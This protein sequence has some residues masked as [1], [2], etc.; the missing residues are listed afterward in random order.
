M[1]DDT[2]TLT[3]QEIG[4]VDAFAK[5]LIGTPLAAVCVL[6]V[7]RAELSTLEPRFAS[8]MPP[9]VSRKR[10]A[11]LLA[12]AGREEG[13]AL[14]LV[15]GRRVESTVLHRAEPAAKEPRP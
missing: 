12:R 6:V 3:D 14:V 4:M 15:D 8:D 10:A 1:S 5:L 9:G 2:I 7:F 13:V 11:E